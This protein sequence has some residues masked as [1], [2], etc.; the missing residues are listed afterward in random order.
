MQVSLVRLGRRP[1]ETVQSAIGP[2]DEE[3]VRS[4]HQAWTSVSPD[5]VQAVVPS[6]CCARPGEFSPRSELPPSHNTI[7]T[8]SVV[9]VRVDLVPV[10]EA[11]R[12]LG[13][14]RSRVHQRIADGSL[15][16]EKVGS[17]WLV[18]AADLR[19]PRRSRP[20]SHRMARAL[21]ELYDGGSPGVSGAEMARLRVKV[22]ALRSGPEEDLPAR[23]SAWLADR[24]ERVELAVHTQDVA[25]L[26]ADRRLALSGI[27]DPR[28]GLSSSV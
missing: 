4:S 19:P 11:A 26:R 10:S 16:A 23:V 9:S 20:M 13:V 27:S 8:C 15:R 3:S 25:Q 1:E 14:N 18:D 17:I 6:A 24:A 2:R 28:A 21:A 5:P 12:R 7:R 22:E